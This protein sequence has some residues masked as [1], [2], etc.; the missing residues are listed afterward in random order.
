MADVT[1]VLRTWWKEGRVRPGGEVRTPFGRVSLLL[2]VSAWVV[3]SELSNQVTALGGS[4]PEALAL[5]VGCRGAGAATAGVSL[6]AVVGLAWFVGCASIRQFH[7]LGEPVDGPGPIGSVVR[8]GWR[9][10]V[11]A[12]GLWIAR[13]VVVVIATWGA[14]ADACDPDAGGL[15]KGL[16]FLTVAALVLAGGAAV[17]GALARRR[18]RSQAVAP[19]ERPRVVR[20]LVVA[21]ALLVFLFL[22]FGD[23][24]NQITEA[25]RR[26]LPGGAPDGR[27][28]EPLL[29]ALAALA[30]LTATAAGAMRAMDVVAAKEMEPV[31]ARLRWTLELLAVACFV[32]GLVLVRTR[33]EGHG[34]MAFGIIALAIGFTSLLPDR[35]PSVAGAPALPEVD[36]VVPEPAR[37]V[38]G[39][40]EPAPDPDAAAAVAPG[41]DPTGLGWWLIAIPAV[42][43]ATVVARVAVLVFVR[44]GDDRT[45]ALA[46]AVLAIVA[47]LGIAAAGVLRRERLGDLLGRRVAALA[48]VVFTVVTWFAVP[49]LSIDVEQR[50]GGIGLVLLF[51]AELFLGAALV[52]WFAERWTPP[53]AL[54]LLGLQRIPVLSLLLVWALLGAY[55]ARASGFHDVRRVAAPGHEAA[56]AIEPEAR[57]EDWLAAQDDDEDMVPLVMVTASGGGIRAAAWTATMLD[58]VFDLGAA[59]PSRDDVP[60]PCPEAPFG[61]L[62]AANGASGGSVGIARRGRRAPGAQRRARLDRQQPR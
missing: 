8:C 37:G 62:F 17:V 6:V 47:C 22:F 18:R 21:E 10:A 25:A 5:G 29:M 4:R 3:G 33:N 49:R 9:F 40:D 27:W 60:A 54:R 19:A 26:W 2:A 51:F 44:G 46:V 42:T 15:R 13:T 56:V 36:P 28:L 30:L 55:L 14:A 16:T 53:T 61:R 24:S 23:L 45:P 39:A 11:A 52:S 59:G 58:C 50:L 57:F 31:P 32:V 35:A 1:R 41:P 48:G 38:R 7:D 20:V 34:L 43:V 12:V